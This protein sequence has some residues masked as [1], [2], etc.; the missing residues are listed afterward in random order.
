MTCE[1]KKSFVNDFKEILERIENQ[2]NAGDI[3]ITYRLLKRHILDL[4]PLNKIPESL[5]QSIHFLE[6]RI[7]IAEQQLIL[8]M[9]KAILEIEKDLNG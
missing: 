5:V 1:K 9:E 2:P 7:E 8:T 6:E 4:F 3:K